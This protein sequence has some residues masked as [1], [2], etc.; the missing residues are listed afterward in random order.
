M[1]VQARVRSPW[2]LGGDLH[3]IRAP[4]EFLHGDPVFEAREG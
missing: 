1:D 4:M 2:E 3:Y